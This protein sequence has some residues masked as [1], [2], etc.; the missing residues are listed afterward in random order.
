[1]DKKELFLKTKTWAEYKS[2]D[3]LKNLDFSDEEI[4]R[5]FDELIKQENVTRP[6]AVDGVHTDYV[7]AYDR[8]H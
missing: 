5:H 8:T 6:F 3:R 1:M 4:N 7:C 2:D